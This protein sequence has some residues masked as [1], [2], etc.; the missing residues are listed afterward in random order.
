MISFVVFDVIKHKA[1]VQAVWHL[2]PPEAEPV[3]TCNSCMRCYRTTVAFGGAASREGWG[4]RS[5][6]RSMVRGWRERMSRINGD[7]W[8]K[9]GGS[10]RGRTRLEK[11][12]LGKPEVTTF[13][14]EE[15]DE[16]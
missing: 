9:E 7:V 4:I 2:L 8:K 13:R 6:R 10:T 5:M 16:Y 3:Q 1:D 15:G 14:N 12:S 11:E